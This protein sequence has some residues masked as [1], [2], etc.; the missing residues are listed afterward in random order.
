MEDLGEHG[1]YNLYGEYEG[2]ME[3]RGNAFWYSLEAQQAKD[4]NSF[5]LTV[6]LSEEDLLEA[7]FQQG[8]ADEVLKK[9]ALWRVKQLV[10]GDKVR[11]GDDFEW[12]IS[13]KVLESAFE[14]SV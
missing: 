6:Y 5:R 8:Q 9:V 2:Q 10:D 4:E 13:H 11:P 3:A 14:E 12:E 1:G 7:G